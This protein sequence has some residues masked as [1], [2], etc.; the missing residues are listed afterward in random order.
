MEVVCFISMERKIYSKVFAIV[1]P[2]ALQNL[3]SSLVSVSDAL[4]L[5]RL[6]QNV[7]SAVSLATQVQFVLNLFFSA[8][9][10]GTTILSAQYWGKGDNESVEKVLGVAVRIS[11]LI[12]LIF[13]LAAQICPVFLM[14]IFTAEEELAAIGAKYLR[15]ASLS[16]LLMAVPQI[17]LCIMKNSGRVLKSTVYGFLTVV[18]NIVL[19]GILI[20]GLFGFPRMEA[21]G[22]AIATDFAVGVE[23]CLVLYENRTTDSVRMKWKHLLAGNQDFLK[24]FI[25]HSSLVIADLLVWGL[26]FTAFSVILG[27]MGN[28]AVA[29]NSIANTAKNIISCFCLGLGTG[30]G[31]IVGNELGKNNLDTAKEYGNQL[32]RIAFWTGIISGVVLILSIPLF[33]MLASSL[34]ST[35]MNYLKLMLLICG[36]YMIGKSINVTLIDGVFCAGGDTRFGLWCDIVVMWL[37]VIP[38]GAFAAFALKWPV[39]VVYLLLSMDEGIKLPAVLKH[40]KKY[41]WV[42]NLTE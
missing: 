41:R 22:A 13:F 42:K 34:N 4:M 21:A 33:M 40:Y 14:H 29:A 26:G 19:N 38:L 25:R 10:A 3:L 8:L 9:I 2:I 32:L 28:D 35:S 1:L 23:L 20:F 18:I 16:Y 6:N 36:I 17:Y 15:I 11:C 24:A 31:I 5:G 7:L 39:P 27:H 30:T 37:I 12:A